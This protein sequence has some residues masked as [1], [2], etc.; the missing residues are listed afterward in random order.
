MEP[1]SVLSLFCDDI[2]EEK[3]GSDILVGILPDNVNVPK[4]PFSFPKMAIYTRINL[5]PECDPG[6]L[7]VTVR[8]PSGV[9][10]FAATLDANV[11]QK[12][13]TEAKASG[14]PIAGL[15]NRTISMNWHVKEPG[16]VTVIVTAHGKEY[17]AGALNLQQTPKEG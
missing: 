4:I 3:R 9:A 16:R 13:I 7:S 11:V 14:S 2:R 5:D 17:L 10:L 15:I 8:S 6:E 12:A 1:I